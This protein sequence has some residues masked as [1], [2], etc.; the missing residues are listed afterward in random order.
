MDI[1]YIK[2]TFGEELSRLMEIISGS[3]AGKQ[4]IKSAKQYIT[5]L[6][7]PIE[8]KNGWQ[9]AEANGDKTPYRTQQFI[10]RGKWKANDVMVRARG[11]IK[12]KLGSDDG[13]LVADETGFL[14]QGE[15]SAGVKRQYSGTAGRVENCQVG[16]F[17]TYSGKKGFAVIDRGLYLPEEWAY[18]KSRR[19]AAGVPEDVEFRTKPQM[20]LEMLKAANAAGMPFG[21]VTADCLY[22][23]AGYIRE[24]IESIGK[25][26]VLSVSGIS[27]VIQGKKYSKTEDIVKSFDGWQR[28]S[29]G[30]GSKGERNWLRVEL[31]KPSAEGFKRRLLV[32]RSISDPKDF[33][34]YICYCPENTTLEKLAQ[35]AGARWT[36]ERSFKEA[37]GEVG[38][39]HYEV[40]SYQGWY[41]HITLSC[42]ALA[43]LAVIKTRLDADTDFQ[44][45]IE[46]EPDDSMA[47]FKKGR[48]L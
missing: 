38:L 31:D 30:G 22:G 46:P 37:K 39:D 47:G 29:C 48:G 16:V 2:A 19:D 17:L 15:H 42:C 8:R 12:D 6:L 36:V 9:L 13:V 28:L 41:G 44:S 4:G 5:G 20:A 26:Y 33:R 45:A 35:V 24:W 34:E 7:S 40:R 21:W 43:L 10:Y 18:Q 11:Y 27:H 14:K 32:R 3:F 23:N 1:E 25:G